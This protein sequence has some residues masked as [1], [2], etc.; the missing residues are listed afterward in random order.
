MRE[1]EREREKK[2]ERRDSDWTI[3]SPLFQSY[4]FSASFLFPFRSFVF[5]DWV[6]VSLSDDSSLVL[7]PIL[8]DLTIHLLRVDVSSIFIKL[9]QR[10]SPDRRNGLGHELV[11]DA[12][13]KWVSFPTSLDSSRTSQVSS[14]MSNFEEIYWYLDFHL[15]LNTVT[16]IHSCKSFHSISFLSSRNR[17]FVRS[18]DL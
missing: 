6:F 4:I 7:D 2:E 17:R 11:H 13:N 12:H 3:I 15:L 18:I 9:S 14:L 16:Y 8:F 1:T 10:Y 5:D